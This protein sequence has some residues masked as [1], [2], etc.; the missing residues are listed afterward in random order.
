MK[1]RNLL[2][3]FSERF[4]PVNMFLFA[5]LFFTVKSVA[6]FFSPLDQTTFL[7]TLWG[8]VAVISFFF[9]L[10]VFDEIKDYK[11]DAIN[12][13]NR[14]LQSGRVT[15]KHLQITAIFFFI[16]EISWTVYNGY[17]T[18][19]FWLILILYS[20][21][22]RYEFFVSNYLKSKLL[23]Y[24]A[25][26]ML[27]M[28]FIILWVWSAFVKTNLFIAPFYLLACLSFL[29]GFCFE[30]ARKTHAPNSERPTVDSYSKS[31]GFINSIKLILLFLSLGVFTQ[32]YM[33]SMINAN[34]WAFLLIAVLFVAICIIY[35][36]QAKTQKESYL[37][38]AELL[39]S[40]FMLFSYLTIIAQIN[41]AL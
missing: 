31:I 41:F 36:L 27:I 1:V 21:L 13:P 28:P 2:A 4:P 16:F 32:F 29:S 8:I 18:L 14:V 17:T 39:V 25:S 15:L 37:R 30:V 35:F 10:R 5:I 20:L 3:Y 38:K 12:H 24:A 7:N 22:M 11:I 33:L 40:L 19:V 23:L 26:H 6:H 34:W 9:R